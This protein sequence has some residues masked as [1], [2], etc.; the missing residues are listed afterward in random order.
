MKVSKS[1]MLSPSKSIHTLIPDVYEVMKSKEYSGDLSSIAMQAGREVEDAIKNAFEPYEQKSELR[2]S[3][4]GRCERA[5]WYGVKGY[6][7]EEIDGNVYLTFLQGHVL[8][9]VLVALVKLAGHTVEDQQKKHTVE[10]VNGSQD[11]TID[12]ELVDIKTAS[13]WSWDNKFT[14]TGIKDDGFGYIKQ[15]SAYGKNDNREHGYFLALNKNKSTLKLCKQ[16]LEQDVDT[17]IVDLKDKMESDT[18]PMRIANAT[19]LTKNGE[20]KLCM[21]CS[22]C[23]FKEDCYGSLIAKPIPSGKITNYFVDN[24]GAS[25]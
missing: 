1:S 3:G 24:T 8:E 12:G 25:F 6:T 18:P 22:F 15:L 2:M 19:T 20:E 23:G 21:T 14:E 10:G 4:I 11:C 16:E 13:A 17:F 5:Q 7:P 9:A